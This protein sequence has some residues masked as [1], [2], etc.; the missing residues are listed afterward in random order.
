[1]TIVP[2]NTPNALPAT[3][4]KATY[5]GSEMEYL[6]ETTVRPI[7][8]VS[9]DVDEPRQVGETVALTFSQPGPVLIEDDT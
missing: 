8:I 9:T 4:S 5:I 2:P 3:I 6:V 1:L 7:F